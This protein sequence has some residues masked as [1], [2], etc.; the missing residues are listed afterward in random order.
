M[1]NNLKHY[2]SLVFARWTRSR[3]HFA[4]ERKLYM[5]GSEQL[6]RS[7]R[8]R[9]RRMTPST[10][11]SILQII[12]CRY[13]VWQ[14]FKRE[15]EDARPPFLRARNPLVLVLFY[16]LFWTQTCPEG[17]G[18]NGTHRTHARC[19]PYPIPQPVE[20]GHTTGVY[21]PYSFRTVVWV[22]LRPTRTR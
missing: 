2:I 15:G 11:C 5:V 13:K 14:A 21:I 16:Q 7:R 17:I 18:T 6:C 10:I 9:P 8:Y 1:N 19:H 3:T 12:R 22:L 20:V 4:S